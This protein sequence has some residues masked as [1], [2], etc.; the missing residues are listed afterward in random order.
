MNWPL[1]DRDGAGG[2]PVW[3]IR[4]AHVVS[5]VPGAEVRDHQA[6]AAGLLVIVGL[7]PG[8]VP[9]LQR[10]TT[11]C[12]L[13]GGRGDPGDLT[14]EHGLAALLHPQTLERAHPLGRPP[15]NPEKYFFGG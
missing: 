6:H 15:G 4:P 11:P 14:H 2:V 9:G 13:D 1:T 10:V 5:L 7:G 8:P 12:P 3:I